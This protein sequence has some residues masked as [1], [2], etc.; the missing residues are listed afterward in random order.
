[1]PYTSQEGCCRDMKLFQAALFGACLLSS[2]LQVAAVDYARLARSTVRIQSYSPDFDYFRPW[3]VLDAPGSIGSGFIVQIEP[4]ILIATNQHVINDATQVTIQMLTLDESTWGVDVVSSCSKFDLALLTL[5]NDAVFKEALKAAGIEPS[6]LA[7]SN[8]VAEMGQDVIALGF[9]LGQNSL[10]V[11]KGNVAGNEIVNSNICIQS[12]APIS[13]G[14]SGGPL[15]DKDGFSVVGVNFAK[16]TSGENVNYVIPAWRVSLLVKKHLKDQP[17]KPAGNMPWARLGFETPGHGLSTVQSSAALYTTSHGCT[18]GIYI[19]K[20]DKR[21]F[22][23]KA[24]PAVQ[25]GSMLVS[26]AGKEVDEFGKASAK[27]RVKGKVAIDDLFFIGDDL[28]EEVELETCFQGKLTKHKVSTALTKDFES[29]IQKVREPILRGLSKEYEIFGDIGV[30]QMTENHVVR[31]FKDSSAASV[32]RWLLPERRIEPRVMIIYVRKGSYT[33]EVLP[34]GATVEK[35]NNQTVRTLDDFRKALVPPKDGDLWTLETDLGVMV[36]TPFKETLLAQVN[37]AK[38][39]KAMAYLMSEGVKQA[40]AKLAQDDEE[41]PSTTQTTTAE[42]KAAGSESESGG[43]FDWIFSWFK[44]FGSSPQANGVVADHGS[45]RQVRPNVDK[46]VGVGLLET[47][48]APPRHEGPRVAAAG[49]LSV[50]PAKHVK[51]VV[52]DGSAEAL[53]ERLADEI[54]DRSA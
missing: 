34:E 19:S 5:Q 41:Q 10:K 44:W 21:G 26:V 32:L 31:S 14:N 50:V 17:K 2:T 22:V 52:V 15:M 12:T 4:Y 28:T 20:V 25:E 45:T 49:P 36:A 33:S 16:S 51:G 39:S 29:G 24:E 9:P 38:N 46:H 1:M 23:S 47:G 43:V 11:S 30:M 7:L 13:P 42:A 37:T 3:H 40:A 54:R 18:K 53:L 27:A 35:V 8:D 48:S 6:M